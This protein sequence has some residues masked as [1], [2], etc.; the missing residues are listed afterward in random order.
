MLEN[1]GVAP[2]LGTKKINNCSTISLLHSA[3]LERW[4]CGWQHM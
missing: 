3:Y 2:K 1:L 4:G